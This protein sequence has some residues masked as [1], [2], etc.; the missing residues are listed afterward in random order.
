MAVTLTSSALTA[1][2]AALYLAKIVAIAVVYH[3]MARVGLSMA[4]VQINTSPVWPPTGIAVASLILLGY[5]VWPGISI[6]VLFGSLITGAD[7]GI[8]IGMALGNTL[9]A[10]ACAYLLRR[11]FAFRSSLDRVRDV[12]AL[13]GVSLFGASIGAFIG[14][15]TLLVFGRIDQAAYWSVWSTWWVGDLLGALVV[16]PALMVWLSSPKLVL[17][18]RRAVEGAL[19]LSILGVLTWY[20]FAGKPPEGILHQALIYVILPFTVWTA[21][22]LG[23]RGA[24]L[25]TLIVSG[26]ATWGTV[27]GLGPFQVESMNDS[28]VLL[29]TFV[30]AV[31]LTALVLASAS[32]ERAKATETL[33]QQA[34]NLSTLTDA[35]RAFLGNSQIVRTYT[36]ICE[37]AI[38]RLGLDVSWIEAA[39]DE[40]SGVSVPVVAGASAEEVEMQRE[41]WRSTSDG[42]ATGAFKTIDDVEPV[43]TGTRFGAYASMP[44]GVGT[45]SLV[46]L[47]VLS[48]DNRFF[49]PER[50]LLIQSYANLAAVAVQNAQLFDEV[51]ASNRQLRAL[52]QRLMR[53]QEEERL[54][55]SR[56]LHDESGQLLAALTVKLGLMERSS[57]DSGSRGVPELKSM[58]AVL[59]EN[60]HGLAVRL[61]PASLDHLGLVTAAKQYTRDFGGQYGVSAKFDVAGPLGRRLSTELETA[62]FRIVQES[63]TNVALHAKASRV[64]V[65]FDFGETGVSVIVED[66]GVGFDESFAAT[67]TH[68]GFFGMRERV[69]M[70]GG[71]IAIESG[72]GSGT[73]IKVEVPYND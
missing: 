2:R 34:E 52:S 29:Q 72:A 36:T 31:S 25:G 16:A 54:R 26:I 4:Y 47:K 22:R 3:L 5:G 69:Q 48:S 40:E 30:G 19:A 56:E 10:L 55:L 14:T 33:R 8:A 41:V 7:L 66:D 53:A 70:L 57:D 51:G 60:L 71:T 43:Q 11:V 21:L 9:E 73:T 27:Q 46:A 42:A 23:Q 50:R 37:L 20:V 63:L 68:L 49:S 1:R 39:A 28:L 67:N 64:D 15:L 65:L 45:D 32:L 12:G 62:L 13:V 44:L 38:D 6:G 58:V 18:I 61:R 35:S 24:A 59:Q 17:N